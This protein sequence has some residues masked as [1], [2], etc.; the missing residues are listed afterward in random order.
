[1]SINRTRWLDKHRPAGASSGGWTDGPNGVETQSFKLKL[2]VALRMGRANATMDMLHPSTSEPKK[3]WPASSEK[4]PDG[5]WRT[6]NGGDQERLLIDGRVGRPLKATSA[7][8]P[9]GIVVPRPSAM[10]GLRR[11]RLPVSNQLLTQPRVM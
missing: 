7:Q 6:S 8:H 1:M 11:K 10:Q 4:I 3:N 5:L 9:D 2:C